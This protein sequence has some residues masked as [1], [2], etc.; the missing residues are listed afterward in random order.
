MLHCNWHEYSIQCSIFHIYLQQYKQILHQQEMLRQQNKI[1]YTKKKK[2]NL[3]IIILIILWKIVYLK[4]KIVDFFI[5]SC[6]ALLSLLHLIYFY[7]SLLRD[8]DDMQCQVYSLQ[9][10]D[11]SEDVIMKLLRLFFYWRKVTLIWW[12]SFQLSCRNI[13]FIL[14]TRKRVKLPFLGWLAFCV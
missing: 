2:R 6:N 12:H 10:L 5:W 11:F 9:W 13:K 14:R 3:H 7:A 1:I 4:K 8:Y